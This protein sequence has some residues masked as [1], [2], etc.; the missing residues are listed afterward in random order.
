MTEMMSLPWNIVSLS[1]R[2]SV[3]TSRSRS[4]SH[5][6]ADTYTLAPSKETQRSVCS[7]AAAPYWGST[8]MKPDIGGT[9]V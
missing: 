3:A 2:I 6:L 1:R 9:S 7:V 5:I 8:W 4:A